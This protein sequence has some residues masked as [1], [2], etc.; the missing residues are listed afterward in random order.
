MKISIFKDME[1][2]LLDRFDAAQRKKTI[3]FL[4]SQFSL[5]EYDCEDIYQDSFLTLYE[6]IES[7]KLKELTSSINTYFVSICKNKALE[8][9]RKR[10]NHTPLEM[11]IPD[12]N[13]HVFLDDKVNYLLSLDTDDKEFIEKKEEL[14]RNVV[15]NLSS[16][17][18]ELLWG[19]Y[20]DGYSMKR[21]AEKCNYP[22]ENTAKVTKHR[23]CEKFRVKYNEMVKSLFE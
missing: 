3:G 14:V 5:S 16:P 11:D 17:C 1:S 4:H 8:L 21:L 12:Q 2:S 22:S 6:N 19:Y 9:L 20:R 7:G 18:D 13:D 15:R 23:C 10:G